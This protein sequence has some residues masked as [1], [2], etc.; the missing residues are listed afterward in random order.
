MTRI[1]TALTT[2]IAAVVLGVFAAGDAPKPGADAPPENHC[3]MSDGAVKVALPDVQQPD[4]TSCGVACFMSII[5]YYGVGPDDYDA[6][7]KKLGTGKNGTNYRRM[8]AFAKDLGLEGRAESNMTLDQL[9]QLVADRKPVICSIQAWNEDAP[10]SKRRRLYA[11]ED[12]NG[13]YVVMIGFDAA[14]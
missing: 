9:L 3:R 14:N 7:R 10:E 6:L 2:V 12:E 5:S 8:I 1:L 4:E 11:D 13:H